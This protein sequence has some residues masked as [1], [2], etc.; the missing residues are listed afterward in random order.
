MW[1]VL[2]KC[3]INIVDQSVPSAVEQLMEEDGVNP[4]VLCKVSFQQEPWASL[5]F[6]L[7]EADS[8]RPS[9]D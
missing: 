6:V 1:S 5:L 2:P 9:L 8:Q 7:Q 4:A 3:M